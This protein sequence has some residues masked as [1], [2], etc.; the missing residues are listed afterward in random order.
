[1]ATET[2]ILC[3]LGDKIL[4][5]QP[6]DSRISQYDLLGVCVFTVVNKEATTL[7]KMLGPIHQLQKTLGIS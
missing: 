5:M 1:M 6:P 4:F 3:L 2:V 7:S